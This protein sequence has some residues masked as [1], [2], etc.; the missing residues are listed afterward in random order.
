MKSLYFPY[1]LERSTNVKKGT[2]EK[3][4]CKDLITSIEAYERIEKE[5]N[6]LQTLLIFERMICF[7]WMLQELQKKN[8]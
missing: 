3:L 4:E 1:C 8:Y 5:L 6:A 2:L 7:L